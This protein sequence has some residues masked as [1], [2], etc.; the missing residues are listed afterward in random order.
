MMVTHDPSL[1]ARTKR[2]IHLLD[3]HVHRDENNGK[4]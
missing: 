2:V 3:G 4:H 1:S